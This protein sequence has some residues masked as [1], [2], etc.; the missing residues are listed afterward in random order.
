MASYPRRNRP[1]E[2]RSRVDPVRSIDLASVLEALYRVETPCET[3]LAGILE[4]LHAAFG[5]NVNALAALYHRSPPALTIERV[6]VLNQRS[7]R[8]I[9]SWAH[10][11]LLDELQQRLPA[12]CA[13]SL[14]LDLSTP[15]PDLN[16]PS[17]AR[18]RTL[19]L[20]GCDRTGGGLAL[21][22][23]PRIALGCAAPVWDELHRLAS[24]LAGSYRLHRMSQAGD[25]NGI[26]A[27]PDRLQASS[28]LSNRE[29]D[30]VHLA[31]QGRHNKW[32]AHEL[33]LS[34]ST[35]RVLLARAA[36]KF[37]AK[38]RDELLQ[39]VRADDGLGARLR[40]RKRV[41]LDDLRSKT[42]ARTVR[43]AELIEGA[44]R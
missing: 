20:S 9:R 7:S 37:G 29:A 14:C 31:V 40:A 19:L 21:Y 26:H 35:V 18:V 15:S 25:A 44:S 34:H 41:T 32:I 10:R 39:L 1:H 3:W 12:V 16:A 17:R 6:D 28:G 33:G 23:F 5:A 43:R 4:A 27:R 38:S 22:L 11:Y 8:S 42:R 2:P 24:H 13:H 30:V 36:K